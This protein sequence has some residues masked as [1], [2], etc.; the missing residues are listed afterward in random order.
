MG[1]VFTHVSLFHFRESSVFT[2]AILELL[3]DE[4]YTAL[5][6]R[7]MQNPTAGDLIKGGGGLRKIRCAAKGRGKS[8]GIR[9]IYYVATETF[10]YLVTAYSKNKQETLT[11]KQLATLSE[12]VKKETL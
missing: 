6:H 4:E 8:G 11:T 3:S 2:K 5:Q 10:I 12:Y 9:V 7:L 1:V